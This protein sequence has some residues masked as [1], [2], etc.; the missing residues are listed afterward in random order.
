MLVA[1]TLTADLT[2]Y[3]NGD[4]AS[5]W[6]DTQSLRGVSEGDAT[7][8]ALARREPL[9]VELEAFCDLLAGDADAPRGHA[10]RGPRDR[11]SS[12]R[13]R[14][15]AHAT[16]R[17][18]PSRWP[19]E[20][21]RRRAGQDRP[22]ARHPDRPRRPRGRRLRHRRGRGRPRQ[23]RRSRRSPARTG[24]PRRWPRSSATG[25]CGRRPTRRRRSPAARSS[26][27]RCRRW[28]STPTP[29]P[30]SARSTRCWPTSAPG[31]QAGTTVAVETTLPVG[32]TRNR[33][34]PALAPPQRPARRG[35]VL[36][37]LQPRARLQ[38]A[39]LPRP[40]DLP[41]A[42]GRAQR[43]RRGARGQALPQLPRRR[44]LADGLRR[45]RRADQARRDHLPRREHRA[46]QRVRALRRPHRHRPRPRHRRRQLAALQPHPPPRGR[47][48][49]ALHPGLSALLPRSRRRRA[50]AGRRARG[51]PGDAGLRRRPARGRARRPGRRARR[52]PR[53][54]LSRQ[55][56]G[57]G[58]QRRLRAC[59]TPSPRAAPS[60]S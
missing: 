17:R 11:R 31:L 18:L 23:R 39:R 3:E 37:R 46:G 48:R 43:G 44:G 36:L 13:R 32:T 26:S 35:R 5:E 56:Q 6:A 22:A 54:R 14:S 29:V 45:G 9:L 21:G 15:P 10:G 60:R 41:Q 40:R 27:W 59:A 25:A 4:V 34:A 50:P 16:A 38:R 51:Q 20:G 49:R 58:L 33:V 1:D 19:F 7:R 28:S 52:H 57:D 2:F 47:G 12:P 42:R 30:T 24:S 53:R 55:R 8:Y